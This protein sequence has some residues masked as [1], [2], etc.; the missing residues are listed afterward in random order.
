MSSYVP[1]IDIDMD[2]VIATFDEEVC[3]LVSQ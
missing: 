3:T 1:D 2:L